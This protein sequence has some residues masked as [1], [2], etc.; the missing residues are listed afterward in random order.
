MFFKSKPPLG[1]R[2]VAASGR[3]LSSSATSSAATILLPEARRPSIIHGQR[4]DPPAACRHS[5]RRLPDNPV[6]GAKVAQTVEQRTENPCVGG[7]I[8]PLRTMFPTGCAE[9]ESSPTTTSATN[10]PLL[11]WFRPQV[12]IE[13]WRREYNGSGRTA[14]VPKRSAVFL[15][16][17]PSNH[18]FDCFLDDAS[19]DAPYGP[20]RSEEIRLNF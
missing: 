14:P 6:T 17:T 10:L 19:G 16:E 18:A 2:A 9:A 11:F 13:R 4:R 15:G 1:A 8:P 5:S 7:S 3:P 12:L 20:T